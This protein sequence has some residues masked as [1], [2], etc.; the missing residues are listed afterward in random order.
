[1]ELAL[2]QISPEALRG[3]IEEYITREGTDYGNTGSSLG[4]AADPHAERTLEEKVAQVRRQLE[5]GEARIVFD[6]EEESASIVHSDLLADA[7]GER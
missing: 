5:D 6:L 3:L 2:D 4:G 7:L 1:M